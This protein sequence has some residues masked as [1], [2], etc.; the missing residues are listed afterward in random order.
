MRQIDKLLVNSIKRNLFLK[1]II[2]IIK[3]GADVNAVANNDF[4]FVLW[5]AF[6]AHRVDVMKLL[7]KKGADPSKICSQCGKNLFEKRKGWIRHGNDKCHEL[8][9]KLE[10]LC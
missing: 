4:G 5:T 8:L 9:D 7:L 6:L 2:Y 1:D 3:M 10:G